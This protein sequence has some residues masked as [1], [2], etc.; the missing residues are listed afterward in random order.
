MID[1]L[2]FLQTEVRALTVSQS[3]C[4]SAADVTLEANPCS[5]SQSEN[6]VIPSSTDQSSTTEMAGESAEAV[7]EELLQTSQAAALTDTSAPHTCSSGP[8]I[9]PKGSHDCIVLEPS[10]EQA[11]KREH[12]QLGEQIPVNRNPSSTRPGELQKVDG[13]IR[14]SSSSSLA[15][16]EEHHH[17]LALLHP[18]TEEL[19]KKYGLAGS[20]GSQGDLCVRPSPVKVA[21]S[22]MSP[23]TARKSSRGSFVQTRNPSVHQ[24]N[25]PDS[26]YD[27]VYISKSI[28]EC[29]PEPR[30]HI[31]PRRNARKSTRGYKCV[32]D[33]LEL[34]TVLQGPRKSSELSEKGNCPNPMAE[35]ITTV[36]PKPTI[37]K[38]DGIPPV[39]LPFAGGCGETAG[40]KTPLKKVAEMEIAGDEDMEGSEAEP[41]VETSQTDQP[42]PR[43]QVSHHLQADESHLLAE[44]SQT[45]QTPSR[46]QSSSH[47]QGS[48]VKTSQSDQPNPEDAENVCSQESVSIPVEHLVQNSVN[49]EIQEYRNE[50]GGPLQNKEELTDMVDAS[51]RLSTMTNQPQVDSLVSTVDNVTESLFV[52]PPEIK[53]ISTPGDSQQ[54]S[55]VISPIGLVEVKDDFLSSASETVDADAALRTAEGHQAGVTKSRPANTA[56]AVEDMEADEEHHLGRN[57]SF[58]SLAQ[59]DNESEMTSEIACTEEESSSMPVSILGSVLKE[60]VE[61]S[62]QEE[63]ES[64][65]SKSIPPSD[66]CL[67]YRPH[68][69]SAK[70]V[71]LSRRSKKTSPQPVV[72]LQHKTFES[73][74]SGESQKSRASKTAVAGHLPAAC[75]DLSLSESTTDTTDKIQLSS[76]DKSND[77]SEAESRVRTRQ[78]YKSLSHEEVTENKGRQDNNE[79]CDVIMEKMAT[80]AEETVTI[81]TSV[82]SEVPDLDFGVDSAAGPS[83]QSEG[84]SLR[85]ESRRIARPMSSGILMNHKG[86]VLRSQSFQ[87]PVRPPVVPAVRKTEQNHTDSSVKAIAGKGLQSQKSSPDLLGLQTLDVSAP[88]SPKFLEVLKDSATQQLIANLNA[89][90]DKMQKGWVQMD[91][92]GQPIAKP[93][94]RGDRLKDIWK[95]KRRIRKPKSSD[96][97]KYSPVQMLFMKTFDLATICRWF[98]QSTET[99]SLVIVKKVNTRLPS[100]TQLGFQSSSGAPGTSRG[101]FPSLQAE[102][103]KKHLKKFPVASPVKSN[104]KNQQ[105]IAK[106]R[107]HNGFHGKGVE[108]VKE[109]TSATRISTKPNCQPVQLHTQV[110]AVQQTV[111]PSANLPASARILRKYSNIREKLQGQSQKFQ[112]NKNAPVKTL[113]TPKHV[114]KKKLA[115]EP[116]KKSTG[117]TRLN[118]NVPKEVKAPLTTSN[119]R[120]VAMGIVEVQGRNRSDRLLTIKSR[121]DGKAMKSEPSSRLPMRPERSCAPSSCSKSLV[122][123]VVPGT[124]AHKKTSVSKAQKNE[125]LKASKTSSRD[126]KE[127]KEPV[128]SGT[129]GTEVSRQTKMETAPLP[130]KAQVLT[131]SQRKMEAVQMESAASKSPRKRNQ[132]VASAPVP[133]K[134]ARTS[135]LKTGIFPEPESEVL[136]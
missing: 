77:F 100:E 107:E 3:P 22:S 29:E 68:L 115:S 60:E 105:L 48:E 95:S 97:Q 132:D 5:M 133:A 86:L 66:R 25:D 121:K 41:M 83:E 53:D 28:T 16:S 17:N 67:R 101:V 73:V 74:L 129:A 33:C 104:P 35:V 112:H 10:L 99:K 128:D 11:E 94:N 19:H 114:T 43:G 124:T 40:Q 85:R 130:L 45:G 23:R 9:Q 30:K 26:K 8:D 123:H 18:S 84:M 88:D 102:R 108:K 34:K 61:T 55:D 93:R 42:R 65:K 71:T 78:S 122:R 111:P 50:C 21:S 44:V 2:R 36:A 119:R 15:I 52:A 13:L 109:Q 117:D 136:L 131:R 27:I 98:L 103:L 20:R 72:G 90:Y 49:L 106:A 39:D 79:S 47:L 113:L 69:I 81:P 57:E 51:D 76:E 82:K 70:H 56:E 37:S 24:I 59:G 116:R 6:V 91:K 125:P 7:Q 62:T 89:R 64:S 1:A 87:N 135:L 32:E 38:P 120:A 80:T 12:V 54:P 14:S 92:E 134:S 75:D 58:C 126:A 110:T 127:P 4:S 46:D 31:S 118:K 63:G 96:G